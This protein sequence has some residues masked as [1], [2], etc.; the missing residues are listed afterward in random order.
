MMDTFYLL[1]LSIIFLCWGSFLNVV[2]H[3]LI[4]NLSIVF[5]RSHCPH[6]QKFITWYDLLPV[7][8]YCLL[9]GRCRSCSHRISYLYPFIEL[10]SMVS[11]V[12]LALHIPSHYFVGYFLFFSALIVSVRSD[13]ETML[14]SRYVTLYFAPVGWVCAYFDLIPLSVS[15]SIIASIVGFGALWAVARMFTYFTGK[16]G[17]GQGDIDLIAC[18]GAFTGLM[19]VWSSLMIGST[20]GA[21]CSIVYCA[22]TKQHYNTPLPFGPFLALGAI[23]HVFMIHQ[24]YSLFYLL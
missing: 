14:L 8:S 23:V 3:R 6:C 24:G 16:D 15:E 4:K 1:A 18:I 13:L 2:G 22:L 19:G 17:L 11:L 21:L 12:S 5:P 9:R 7:I 10:L 20:V